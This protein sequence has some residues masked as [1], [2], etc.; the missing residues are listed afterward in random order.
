MPLFWVIFNCV[1]VTAFTYFIFI[2]LKLLLKPK[3]FTKPK[4][5]LILLCQTICFIS[6]NLKWSTFAALAEASKI[7]I[8]NNMVFDI[9]YGGVNVLAVLV[10]SAS[11]TIVVVLYLLMFQS[12]LP[13]IALSFFL[14]TTLVFIF[15]IIG[16]SITSMIFHIPIESIYVNNTFKASEEIIKLLLLYLFV[17]FINKLKI[18]GTNIKKIYI[19]EL[20]IVLL[21]NFTAFIT[22][23]KQSEVNTSNAY[24]YAMGIAV[25]IFSIFIIKIIDQII[26]YF[27]QEAEWFLREK[28]YEMQ[29]SYIR[30]M[31][32]LTY[33]LKAQRHDFNH[34]LGCIY[35]LLEADKPLEAKA[36]AQQL[37]VDFQEVNTIVNVDNAVISAL[38]NFKLAAAKEKG[39]DL[40]FKLS[41]LKDMD[42]DSLDISIVLGNAL[43]NALEACEK[44]EHKFIIVEL[45]LQDD[46]LIINIANSK[47]GQTVLG[48]NMYK[49]T[50][51][52][53][54]NHGFGIENIK[55]VVDKYNGILRMDEKDTIFNINIALR[56]DRHE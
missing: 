30:N 12:S 53:R 2:F 7:K 42:I 21:I 17:W 50:K 52:D 35:G 34:Y 26:K 47:L 25:V 44:A 45:Y 5:A 11:I 39:I 18:S 27:Q 24:V 28:K 20:I 15:T 16:R 31:E 22:L 1:Y 19:Y 23:R 29:A 55:H 8:F 41:S 49:T 9:G 38:L 51:S 40:D 54:E 46:Y 37:V 43:D 14:M 33:R 48:K 4:L 10:L 36:Y 56:K 13:K 32:E 3:P 6:M